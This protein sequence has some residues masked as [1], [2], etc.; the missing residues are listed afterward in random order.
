VTE[1]QKKKL[2]ALEQEHGPCAHAVTGDGK[3]LAFRCPSLDEWEEYQDNLSKGKRRGPTFRDLAQQVVV[4]P[5]VEELQAIFKKM[6]AISARIAD[7]IA[8]L[9][10]AAVEV[11]VKKD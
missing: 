1:E 4:E 2:E 7:G 6:P 9:A 3:L 10:G 8:D 5:S 11:S